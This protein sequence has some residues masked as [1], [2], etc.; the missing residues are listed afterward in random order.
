M[1]YLVDIP[2]CTYNHEKYIYQAINGV[3]SQETN[4]KFRLLIGED[5][6]TDN[7]RDII[8]QLALQ[9]PHIIFPYYREHNLGA[10]ENSRLLIEECKSKYIALC[11]GDDYWTDSTKLQ[12]QVDF[13]ESNPD[14]AFCYH[15]VNIIQ[16]VGFI[17]QKLE[18]KFNQPDVS[19]IENILKLNIWPHINSILFRRENMPKY[20]NWLKDC[21]SGDWGIWVL[22]TGNKKIKYIPETMSV[23]R[24]H[25]EGF[26]SSNTK[27]QNALR[28]L[29]SAKTLKKY[30][31]KSKL[32]KHLYLTKHYSY[33][34]L[35]TYHKK[36][37]IKL[38]Y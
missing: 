35:I 31:V 9:Y 2:I 21:P 22:I 8:R 27:I 23:Y 5:C 26:W 7:T 38:F 3:L 15:H 11:D 28:T 12:K 19:T 20:P 16:E 33:M 34:E 25:S 17:N 37:I 6:S 24:Q 13:L 32:R 29:K 36:N 10:S 1:N 4:F 14:F 18:M 30:I